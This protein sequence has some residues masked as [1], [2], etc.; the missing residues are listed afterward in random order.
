MRID[1]DACKARFAKLTQ[2]V[3]HLGFRWELV[4]NGYS[5]AILPRNQIGVGD[6]RSFLFT[7]SDH[8]S[9]WF[10]AFP[11]ESGKLAGVYQIL[12][13]LEILPL[14]ERILASPIS[15]RAPSGA[16]LDFLTQSDILSVSVYDRL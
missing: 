12:N 9:K 7:L 13:E 15:R 16:D 4:G 11:N 6:R 5:I 8:G 14:V 1:I 10:V 3:E 2:I